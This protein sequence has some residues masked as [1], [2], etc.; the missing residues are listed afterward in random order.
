[1]PH[2]FSVYNR[3]GEY[4][5]TLGFPDR[6][7]DTTKTFSTLDEIKDDV[8]HEVFHAELTELQRFL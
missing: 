1:M 6:I 2:P 5:N 4:W 3:L 8:G 7:F